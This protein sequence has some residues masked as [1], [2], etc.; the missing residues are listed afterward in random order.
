MP[1]WEMKFRVPIRTRNEILM[2]NPNMYHTR[3]GLTVNLISIPC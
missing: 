1:G 3:V 2:K